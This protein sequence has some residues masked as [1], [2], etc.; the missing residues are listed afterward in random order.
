MTYREYINGLRAEW[1]GRTVIYNGER[2]K[3]IDVDYNGMLL[4]DK[5]A[6]YTETTAVDILAVKKEELTI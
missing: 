6:Q 5:P 2:H 1:K 4:I 3:V